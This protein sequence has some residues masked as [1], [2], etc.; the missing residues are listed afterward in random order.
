MPTPDV[1]ALLRLYHS[2]P[3][4][5]HRVRPADRA[6]ARDLVHRQIPFELLRGAL[7]LGCARR[8]GSASALPPI[9]SLH[10]F[11]PVLD[12]L[13][14]SQQSYPLEEGYLAYLE[15]KIRQLTA[16]SQPA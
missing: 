3:G 16:P 9:R 5:T 10:Y 8:L 4:T 15:R 6:L 7:L 2:L 14:Q 12:E 13:Q 11:L 1:D